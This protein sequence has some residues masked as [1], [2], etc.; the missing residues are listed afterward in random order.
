RKKGSPERV[1]SIEDLLSETRTLEEIWRRM[2]EA[3]E[4]VEVEEE[5][6]NLVDGKIGSW[7]PCDLPSFA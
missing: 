4:T 7:D 3:R 1:R 6:Y 2:N 5:N